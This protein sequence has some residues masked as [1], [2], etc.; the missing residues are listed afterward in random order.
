MILEEEEEE[1]IEKIR[2]VFRGVFTI[3]KHLHIKKEDA[4]MATR[5]DSDMCLD[6]HKPQLT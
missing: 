2:C 5:S 6:L 3:N 4:C 1:I